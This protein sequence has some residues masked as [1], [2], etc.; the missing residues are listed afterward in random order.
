MVAKGK[1]IG[2][3]AGHEEYDYLQVVDREFAQKVRIAV[4]AAPPGCVTYFEG[5]EYFTSKAGHI[6]KRVNG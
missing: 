5:A 3:P 2:A 1:K 4:N 6:Y